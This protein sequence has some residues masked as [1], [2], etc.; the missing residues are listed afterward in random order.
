MAKSQ[1][2]ASPIAEG[3]TVTVT[4]EVNPKDPKS[5]KANA[6]SGVKTKKIVLVDSSAGA[7]ATA[8]PQAGE[9]WICKIERITNPHSQSH[10][11][12]LVR[13][14]S[15]ETSYEFK[16]VYVAP[17]IAKTMTVVL[18][19]RA[20]NLFL[21]G[22]QGIGKSTIARA[23]AKSLGWEFR[24]VSCG[25]IK[26]FTHMLGRLIPTVGDDGAMKMIWVDSR[27]VSI[28]REAGRPENR[29]K[30]FL[31]M[32][33]EFTR[34]EED[35]RDGLLDIIEGQEREL[36]LPNG[37]MV[38]VPH[39]VHFM[40]AGNAGQGF[41]VR[42]EDAAA[43]DRWVIVKLT[44]MP[45]PEEQKHCLRLFPQCPVKQLDK[46]LTVVNAVRKARHDPKR[47]LSKSPS[48]RVT[49]N[50]AMMLQSGIDL[51]AALQTAVVNQYLGK[52][53]DLNSEAGKVSRILE[54]ELKR[55]EGVK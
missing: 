28:L 18:Q 32:L 35:A 6:L 22:D 44:H 29:N 27:V 20:K 4:F 48:T 34:M 41:T 5:V 50:I 24:K 10:G 26:K 51:R 43:K 33:D 38:K 54:E 53:E 37:D 42:A 17:D 25:L 19:N 11:A 49:E 47:M 12:I 8:S 15:R 40:A 46:A 3:T 55:L 9:T 36:H 30:T 1:D 21:E 31:L 52:A 14:L 2:K 13:P 23:V 39:N 45:Q 16:D 7:S